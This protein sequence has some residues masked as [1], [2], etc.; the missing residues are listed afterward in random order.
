MIYITLIK[1]DTY[2]H[3][4][5]MQLSSQDEVTE[6]AHIFSLFTPMSEALTDGFVN[7]GWP[8]LPI[9][10]LPD[11]KWDT[12]SDAL[13]KHYRDFYCDK[14]K[15]IL[16]ASCH[17]IWTFTNMNLGDLVLVPVNQYFYIGRIIGGIE[18]AA[19]KNQINGWIRKVDWISRNPYECG[20]CHLNFLNSNGCVPN[21]D[22]AKIIASMQQVSSENNTFA[23]WRKKLS[24]QIKDSFYSSLNDICLVEIIQ[25]LIT[26]SGGI[27]VNIIN[28]RVA[29]KEADVVAGFIHKIPSFDCDNQHELSIDD[30]VP[31][32]VAFNF[33]KSDC[34]ESLHSAQMLVQTLEKEFNIDQGV[35]VSINEKNDW[36]LLSYCER[37]GISIM[38]ENQIIDWILTLSYRVLFPKQFTPSDL[39]VAQEAFQEI[40]DGYDI[41]Q[42]MA[43]M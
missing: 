13:L 29:P 17:R 11:Y 42:T 8:D 10:D 34:D 26:H 4:T 24:P 22:A 25:Q 16:G 19:E 7:I 30:Y 12:V 35:L 23:L 28:G 5:N 2:P 32:I 1:M 27:K 15:R 6:F 31:H 38:S 3:I 39:P 40:V 33:A 14:M 18:S 43:E 41:Y 36:R 20:W 21:V 9:D 37:S